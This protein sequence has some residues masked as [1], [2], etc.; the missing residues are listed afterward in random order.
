MLSLFVCGLQMASPVAAA[1]V[2]DHGSYYDSESST[3]TTWKTYQ[4]SANYII[5]KMKTYQ[6]GKIKD[7]S[8]IT[9]KKVSA[10]KLKLVQVFQTK[11]KNPDGLMSYYYVKGTTYLKYSSNARKF[12]YNEIRP[13]LLEGSLWSVS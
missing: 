12:Y 7:T 2:I 10:K 5:V 8:T 4:Y 6:K 3:A 9:I 11:E 1:K 13:G